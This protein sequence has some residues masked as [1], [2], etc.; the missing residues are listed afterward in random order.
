VTPVT[1]FKDLSI[2]GYSFDWNRKKLAVAR[3]RSL[4]DVV[5]ITQQTAAQ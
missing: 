3:G 5:L 4:T 2:F 1:E